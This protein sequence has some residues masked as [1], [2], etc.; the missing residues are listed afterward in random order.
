MPPLLKAL[1]RHK[2]IVGLL[3]IELAV[4]LA[5]TINGLSI[6]FQRTAIVRTQSGVADHQILYVSAHPRGIGAFSASSGDYANVMNR[7]SAIPGTT[8]VSVTNALPFSDT[9]VWEPKVAPLE[10]A[11][12]SRTK[13]KA[14]AYLGDEKLLS[15]LGAT[16]VSG[17]GFRADE[18]HKATLNQ[19]TSSGV[20][21]VTRALANKLFPDGNVLGQRVALDSQMTTVVGVV[22]NVARPNYYGVDTYDSFFLP[23]IPFSDNMGRLMVIRLADDADVSKMTHAVQRVLEIHGSDQFA[24]KV[25]RLSDTRSD[26]FKSDRLAALVLGVATLLLLVVSCAGVAGLCQ[27]WVQHRRGQIA[28]RRALGAR[29]RDVLCHIALENMII[30]LLAVVAGCVLSVGLDS[31]LIRFFALQRV[32]IF[33]VVVGAVVIVLIGLVAVASPAL[34]MTRVDPAVVARM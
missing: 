34:R 11:E 32:S 15:A 18:Y 1:S 16:I 33:A 27:F 2:I 25:S 6:V 26:Y 5:L 14:T 7:I 13:M 28:I 19:M 4:T 24:W 29:R 22:S 8:V 30:S 12:H 23:A 31:L 17:R 20:V 10:H 21:M 9:R 3:I